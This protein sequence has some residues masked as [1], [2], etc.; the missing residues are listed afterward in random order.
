[1]GGT[2]S[3]ACANDTNPVCK[4]VPLPLGT[5]KQ[6]ARGF[7]Q[8]EEIAGAF[9]AVGDAR[10]IQF[11]SGLL[12]QNRETVSET[13][14]TRSQ[15]QSNLRGAFVVT[16][17]EKLRGKSILLV[18]DVM[19]SDATARECARIVMNGGATQAFVATVARAA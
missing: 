10:S 7:N 11:E 19:I 15:R 9:C 1:M 16:K 6:R 5:G 17:P 8:A 18:D 13:G 2:L 3:F 12:V 14:L 4:V